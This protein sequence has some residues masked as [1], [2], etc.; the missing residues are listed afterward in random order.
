[1]FTFA[2]ERQDLMTRI[3]I[4]KV[5][6]LVQALLCKS[7]KKEALSKEACIYIYFFTAL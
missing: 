5:K 2:K 3:S 4:H 7:M 6:Q 1:M